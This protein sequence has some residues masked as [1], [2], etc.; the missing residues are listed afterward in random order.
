MKNRLM[1]VDVLKGFAIMAVVLF[2]INF[3][4]PSSKLFNFSILGGMWHVPLFFFISGFFISEAKLA[5][6]KSFLWNKM[7][8][9]YIKGL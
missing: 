8:S 1:Y 7:K 6:T 9:L 5:D 3:E 4:F 2:H